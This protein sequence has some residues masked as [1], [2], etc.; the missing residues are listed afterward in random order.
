MIQTNEKHHYINSKANSARNDNSNP[1]NET[2]QISNP[3]FTLIFGKKYYCGATEFHQ[4][5]QINFCKY[6]LVEMCEEKVCDRR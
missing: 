6:F 1:T 5:L 3:V 4:K 2:K